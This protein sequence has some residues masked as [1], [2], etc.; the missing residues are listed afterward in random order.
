[1]ICPVQ[2]SGLNEYKYHRIKILPEKI[3]LLRVA[4]LY[5]AVWF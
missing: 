2:D 1:M 5:S 3:H 4:L